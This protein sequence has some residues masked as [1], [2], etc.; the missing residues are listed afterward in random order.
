M[1]YKSLVDSCLLF[2]S[3]GIGKSCAEIFARE[4]A[5]VVVTDIDA[6]KS[7]FCQLTHVYITIPYHYSQV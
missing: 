7:P 4:G 3:Q 1:L 6:G 2:I 5:L